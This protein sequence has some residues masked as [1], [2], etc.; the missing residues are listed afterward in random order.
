MLP[1][2]PAASDKLHEECGVIAVYRA[3]GGAA[4]LAHRGLFA[5]QH[6]GQESAGLASVDDS[7]DVH[8]LRSPGLVATAMP[9]ER[10]AALPGRMAIGHCRYSTVTVDHAENIQPFLA[11]SPF[12]RLGIAHNGNFKNAAELTE[13]LRDQGALLST[14]MDTELFV[15]LLTR[16]GHR[17]FHAALRTA[18]EGV[19]GAYSLTLLCGQRLFGLRDAHGVRPLVLGALPPSDPGWVIA[20]ETCAL[21][22]VGATYLREI[23]PGELVELGPQGVLSTQLLAPSPTPSPCVFELV[24]F[25]RPDSEVF[26]QSAHAAR[27]RMGAELALKDR[28]LPR[29]DVVVPVP[30]SGVPAAVGYARESGVPFDMAILRSHYVGRTF[31]LPSQDART[32]SI[33]LKLSVVAAAVAGKRVLLVDDSLVRGNTAQKLV[34]MVREAGAREVWLR[35]ASPPITM[36][37]FLGIDTPNRQ[38]LLINQMRGAAE[39]GEGLGSGSASPEELIELVRKFVGADN[40]RYLSLDGLRRATL[41]RPFCMGCMD[42]TYPV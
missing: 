38:E 34:A 5:L 10:V 31:I 17:D 26:G 16:S 39:D 19:V 24:Y 18:A 33:R 11:T 4:D 27:V 30:D 29:P 8:S 6:R 3:S 32:H 36:P 37:C 20:S 22:A 21:T 9:L 12:G 15:H 1:S 40:L 28:D 41:N 23:A 35:L 42:G 2:C 25:S 13:S 14:T 7:G